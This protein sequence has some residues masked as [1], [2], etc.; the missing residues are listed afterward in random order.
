MK[1]PD[2]RDKKRDHTTKIDNFVESGSGVNTISG[3]LLDEG[4]TIPIILDT[5]SY[6]LLFIPAVHHGSRKIPSKSQPKLG[7]IPNLS[8]GHTL[9]IAKSIEVKI[10]NS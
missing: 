3:V 8:D 6:P 10:L 2:S 5:R 9:L 1:L 4:I 7:S